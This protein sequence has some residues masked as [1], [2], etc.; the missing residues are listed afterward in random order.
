MHHGEGTFNTVNRLNG[1]ATGS[2]VYQYRAGAFHELS[3]GPLSFCR[4]VYSTPFLG[5]A[6]RV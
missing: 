3:L 5:P 6:K 2:P 1:E 4:Q